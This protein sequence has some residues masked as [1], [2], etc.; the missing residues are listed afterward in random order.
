MKLNIRARVCDFW[1]LLRC[2]RT[3]IK[4]SV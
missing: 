1:R 2:T 3:C 4:L